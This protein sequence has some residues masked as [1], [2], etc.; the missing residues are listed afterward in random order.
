[1]HTKT[2]MLFFRCLDLSRCWRHVATVLRRFADAST[3]ACPDAAT[4]RDLGLDASEWE[5]VQA[6]S[7]GRIEVTRRR[8]VLVA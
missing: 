3:P 1:M 8:V 6:E 2:L 4:L 5:S 7:A